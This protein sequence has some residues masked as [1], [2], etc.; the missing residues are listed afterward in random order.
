M[1]KPKV[2]RHGWEIRY[3]GDFGRSLYGQYFNYE[4]AQREL[5]LFEKRCRQNGVKCTGEIQ[6]L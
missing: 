6:K 3:S 1:Q 2:K 5:A 4:D